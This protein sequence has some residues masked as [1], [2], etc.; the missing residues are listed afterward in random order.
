MFTFESKI[1]SVQA[2]QMKTQ[3]HLCVPTSGYLLFKIRNGMHGELILCETD[4]SIKF[5]TKYSRFWFS[6]GSL[7]Q[8]FKILLVE[9]KG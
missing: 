9:V 5:K 2:Q 6:V 3:L 1:N 7:R 4:F 8:H